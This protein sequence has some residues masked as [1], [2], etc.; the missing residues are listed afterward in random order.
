ME[1]QYPPETEPFRAELREWLEANLTDEDRRPARG[2]GGG[3]YDLEVARRWDRK[4]YEGGWACVAWPREYGGRESGV[5]EQLIY[6]EEMPRADAPGHPNQLGI[7]EIGPAI[8]AWGT[9]EQKAHLISRML[10][11]EDMWCQ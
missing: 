3:R 6:E 4:L 1:F 5:M 10:S 9:V 8:L 11:R 7:G 2:Y